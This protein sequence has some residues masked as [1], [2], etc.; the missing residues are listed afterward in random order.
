MPRHIAAVSLSI[1]RTS[2]THLGLLS[3]A[4]WTWDAVCD[5]VNALSDSVD[6]GAELEDFSRDSIVSLLLSDAQRLER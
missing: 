5:C 3:G 1:W 2:S 6:T 4:G